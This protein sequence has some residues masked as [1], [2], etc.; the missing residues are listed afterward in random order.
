MSSR[1]AA[2]GAALDRPTSSVLS[3]PARTNIPAVER[4]TRR[5]APR[6]LRWA[7][8]RQGAVQMDM[9]DPDSRSTRR[10]ATPA[11]LSPHALADRLVTNAEWLEFMEDDGYRRPE[12]WLSDG[13]AW[14][15]DNAIQ[16]PLYWRVGDSCDWNQF[17]LD[18]LRPLEM[19]AP[20]C[21][22]SYYEADA[23]ARW[24]GPG[25]PRRPSGRARQR[26]RIRMRGFCLMPP[27]HETASRPRARANASTLWRRLAMD[28]FGLPALS[29]LSAAAGADR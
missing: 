21:H 17:G 27:R 9:T 23:F 8:G 1:R 16:A 29:R 10:A 6:P 19:S 26:R 22:V 7:E 13:W 11:W 15:R 2:S 18:G 24:A 20:V 25:F 12:L 3:E 5:S 28:R 4:S 14:V